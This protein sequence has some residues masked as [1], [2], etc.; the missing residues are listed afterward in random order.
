MCDSVEKE[1]EQIVFFS[2]GLGPKEKARLIIHE[3]KPIAVE[4][5]GFQFYFYEAGLPDWDLL[6]IEPVKHREAVI[7]E[8]EKFGFKVHKA[9]EKRVYFSLG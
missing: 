8:L 5:E 1:R 9:T 3:G 7:R 2:L 4:V 6:F